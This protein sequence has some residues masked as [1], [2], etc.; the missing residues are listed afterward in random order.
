M[1][2]ISYEPGS[3]IGDELVTIADK[4]NAEIGELSKVFQ[5]QVFQRAVRIGTSLEAARKKILRTED[6][7]LWAENSC[8]LK[9]RQIRNYLRFAKNKEQIKALASVD[10]HE[11][12]S[13]D[14]GLQLLSR[15]E[16]TSGD[17]SETCHLYKRCT[18]STRRA[19]KAIELALAAAK[20]INPELVSTMDLQAIQAAL[21][22]LT[23]IG[24]HQ[25]EAAPLQQPEP[26]W[27]EI[28]A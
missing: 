19:T 16:S 23:R 20:E 28:A 27:T 6:F 4:I 25:I 24:L 17:L 3:V 11:I 8:G 15:N 1:S 26:Q 5:K 21:D 22:I 12:T 14:S 7:Y 10:G 9:E 2:L 18:Q 13:I